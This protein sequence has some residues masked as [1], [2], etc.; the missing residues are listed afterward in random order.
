M[1]TSTIV[2]GGSPPGWGAELYGAGGWGGPVGSGIFFL[3]SALAIA[4]NVVQLAFNNVVYYSGLL[5]PPDASNASNYV[6]VAATNTVGYDGNPARPVNVVA[7]TPVTSDLP[8]GAP[9]GSVL[10]V[11]TDRPMTPY[12][13]LYSIEVSGLFTADLSQA[14]ANTTL[15][16]YGLYRELVSPS[17]DLPHPTRDFANPSS[18]STA[19]NLPNPQNPANLGVFSVSNGDYAF[20]QGMASFK[21]RV[22]RR[23]IT[24]PGGFLH[25]GKG[26]GVGVP[27]QGKK[28]ARPSTIRALSATAEKQIGQE[29]ETQACSV[30]G[31]ASASG[32]ARFTILVKTKGGQGSKFSAAFPTNS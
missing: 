30:T 26:Y 17:V 21:K 27:Q 24:R 7:I 16:Y 9:S 14:L 32:E 25:L 12:P 22:Y 28:L 10:D 3:L 2:P 18:L 15:G 23:L 20:D 31:R 5:D 4:E 6:I 1:P 19:I 11:T 13:A 29:P 8:N